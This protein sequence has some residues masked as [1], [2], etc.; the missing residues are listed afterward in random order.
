MA[1]L[2]SSAIAVCALVFFNQARDPNLG[3]KRLANFASHCTDRPCPELYG[4]TIAVP[5]NLA[6]NKRLAPAISDLSQY[7]HAMTGQDF[8]V[9]SPA[10]GSSVNLIL[11]GAGSAVPSTAAKRLA[12]KGLEAFVIEATA[13]GLEITANDVQGLSH[14]IYYYLEQLGVRWLLPGAN[15][16]VVPNRSDVRLTIDRLVAPQFKVRSYAGTGGFYSWR[17]GRKYAQSK[18][19]ETQTANWI[20]RLRYGGEYSLG[21]HTGEAFISDPEILKILEQHPEY[22]AKIGGSW[23]P[24]YVQDKSGKSVPNV[25]AKLNAGNADV[26]SMYC[27]WTLKKLRLARASADRRRHF[28]VS[29]EPSDG[30]HYGDK[31][32][33]QPGDGSASDQTFHIANTCAKAVRSE[34]PDASVVLLAYAGHAA[35]PSFP[36]E[37][38]VIVQVAPYAFQDMPPDELIAA[39]HV[40][41]QRLA[42]YDYWSIPD[43][44]HDEPVF[45]YLSIG[46]KLRSWHASGIEA[47]NAESTYGAGAMGLGHYVASHLMWS[48]DQDEKALV[49]N[50]YDAAFGPAK[51]PMKRMLQR[52][53]MSFN[54]T[55]AEL[56]VSYRDLSIALKLAKGRA[57]VSARVADFGRYLQYLRL[58]YELELEPDPS[59]KPQRA[60]ALTQHLVEI[61]NSLMVHGTRNIDLYRRKFSVIDTEF[62]LSNPAQPGPGWARVKRPGDADIA[63]LINDGLSLYPESDIEPMQ[64]T[65]GL[66]PVAKTVAPAAASPEFGP[67]MPVAGNLEVSVTIP[68]GLDALPIRVTRLVGIQIRATDINGSV[69]ATGTVTQGAGRTDWAEISLALL[70]GQYR[71]NFRP[72]GGRARGFYSFQTLRDVPVTLTKFLSPKGTP[73]PR[74][75]FYV[76]P[77]LKNLAMYYPLGDFGGVFRFGIR[78]PDSKLVQPRYADL[79]R[80]IV[81]PIAAGQDGKVWSLERSVSPSQPHLM[82]NAPQAFSLAPET[83]MV[84]ASALKGG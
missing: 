81:V 18:E 35:P 58:R 43:W 38:N 66:V 84:P 82:L 74:L 47:L 83:L 1:G 39:W 40:K 68:A 73:S 14:G 36:L 37:P 53:A 10:N 42:L 9:T 76:P 13:S 41:A 27:D 62:D 4:G 6:A 8:L 11:T 64:F 70:P 55:A 15:W 22:L 16:T 72:A 5:P 20:R 67:E 12:G 19:T 25:L 57:D 45:D 7:L 21:S 24:L 23:S 44:S 34:F 3:P 33:D 65:G 77:G 17:W 50:W 59:A 52:W 29:V 79:H 49:E 32:A 28:S 61:D 30:G 31:S 80:T 51:A 75:Y 69:V 78:D 48:L 2:V 60:L 26:V 56:G 54:L 63:R 71:I 46:N